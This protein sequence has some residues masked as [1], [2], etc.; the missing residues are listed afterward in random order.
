MRADAIRYFVLSHFG[1]IYID[2]DD[3]CQRSLDPLLA[4]PAWVR[5]TIPTGV[6]ND[7][8]GSV[9]GHPFFLRVID[10][11]PKYNRN[12]RFPYI[13]IMASTGPLFLSLIWRHY[14]DEIVHTPENRIRILFPEEYMSH[15]WSFFTHHVGSS[16]HKWD[17]DLLFWMS[18]HWIQLT[19]VGFITG[20]SVIGVMWFLYR[21]IIAFNKGRPS[22]RI[23]A[24]PWSRQEAK[25]MELENL[26]N[27]YEA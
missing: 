5:R 2:L 11:L 3:G 18:A 6:S 24:W 9:P 10:S 26:E 21:K 23:W 13:T 12:W 27:R 19:I 20:F 1:G 14:N 16:W 17:S 8:M 25:Y 7:V 22:A 4:Y 15:S